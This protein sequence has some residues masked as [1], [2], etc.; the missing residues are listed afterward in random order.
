MERAPEVEIVDTYL[1]LFGEKDLEAASAYLAPGA[2]LVFPGGLT[3]DDLP[4][5]VA[6]AS[7]RYKWVQ[8]DRTDFFVGERTSDGAVSC[9][10]SGALKGETLW[11]TSFAGVRYIDLFIL[12]DGLIHEQY[13]W[14]DLSELG[15]T[16]LLAQRLSV[17]AAR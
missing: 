13:V 8:K 12:R 7:H 11:G 15:V 4:S 1:R 3:F 14:N 6:D 2:K 16:P 10:S 17:G 9:I 5:V